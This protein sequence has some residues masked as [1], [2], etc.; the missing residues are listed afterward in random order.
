M[1]IAPFTLASFKKIPIYNRKYT[2][3]VVPNLH[4]E[5]NTYAYLLNSDS[6]SICYHSML[7]C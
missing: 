7:M 6:M 3:N 5:S 1:V 4:Y 2:I